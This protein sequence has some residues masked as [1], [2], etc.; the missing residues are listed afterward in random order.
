M[1]LKPRKNQFLFMRC[2]SLHILLFLVVL[3]FSLRSQTTEEDVFMYIGQDPVYSEEFIPMYKRNLSLNTKDKQKDLDA[4]LELFVVYKQKL[5]EAKRLNL[6]AKQE[7]LK[8]VETYKEDV[9]QVLFDSSPFTNSLLE[10]IYERSFVELHASHILINL[11]SHLFGA[12]TLKAYDRIRVLRE[13]ALSGEDFN[14]LAA[15]Y[16]DEVS[17]KETRGDLGCFTAMQMLLPFEDAAFN[18]PVGSISEVVR[19]N[20][21]YHILKVHDKRQALGRLRAAHILIFHSQNTNE[22]EK[23]IQEAYA[24]L[25]KGEGFVEVAQKYSQDFEANKNQAMLEDFG[26]RDIPYKAFVDMAYSL[27]EGEYSVPFKTDLGWHIVLLKE[28]IKPLTKEIKLKEI[29]SFVD[30]RGVKLLF[31]KKSTS[32]LLSLLEYKLLEENYAEDLLQ[33]IDRDYLLREKPY[34]VL[35]KEEDKDLLILRGHVFKYNDFLSY[36]E[37]HK[38]YATEGM[39]TEQVMYNALLDFAKRK[40]ISIYMQEVNKENQAYLYEVKDFSNAILLYDLMQQEVWSKAAKDSLAH[41][42]YYKKHQE[43][44]DLSASWKLEVYQTKQEEEAKK[45]L[46]ELKSALRKAEKGKVF[47]VQPSYVIWAEDSKQYQMNASNLNQLPVIIK[48]EEDYIVVKEKTY[49][50][51]AK[52]DFIS[53][54]EEVIQAYMSAFEK[55]WL[56]ALENKHKLKLKKK[57]WEKL[58][59]EHI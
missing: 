11:S 2:L 4:F 34:T 47:A 16:S 44:F 14:E 3:P 7:Y 6:D 24:A 13:R 33:H 40:A 8:E 25:E 21:G 48:T 23:R 46:K 1:A 32:K 55:E 54:K 15:A 35:S 52:R 9:A 45:T 30:G 56:K 36:L 49:L 20:Y 43:K 27:Q 41:Q 10:E 58:K 59:S 18:T 26:N 12:D 39:S 51:T 38:Q 17:I 57:Q 28:R 5:A 42:E 31:D 19:S 53:A 37:T 50:P 22:D 29:R